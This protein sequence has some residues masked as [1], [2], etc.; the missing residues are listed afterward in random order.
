MLVAGQRLASKDRVRNVPEVCCHHDTCTELKLG[1]QCTETTA[2]RH[3]YGRGMQ[4]NNA[5]Y[6]TPAV[7][8]CN[9]D[10][11]KPVRARIFAI[12]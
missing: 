6:T 8:L 2:R 5:N 11:E 4:S 9:W 10:G 7:F 3:I 12:K 1:I